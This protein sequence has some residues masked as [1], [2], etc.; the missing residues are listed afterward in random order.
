MQEEEETVGFFA[1]DALL[2]GG[3]EIFCCGRFVWRGMGN[4]MLR[5]LCLVGVEKS[6]NDRG[7]FYCSVKECSVSNTLRIVYNISTGLELL[8]GF[9]HS[10]DS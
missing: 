6:G 5:T 1:T 3:W 10:S 4:L 9:T 2:G 7:Y 8:M